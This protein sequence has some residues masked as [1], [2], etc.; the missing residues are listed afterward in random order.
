MSQTSIKLLILICIVP[1]DKKPIF[2]KPRRLPAP[3]REI[4]EQQVEEWIASGIIEPC[5]SEYASPVVV[6][7]KDGTARVCIDY[8]KINRIIEKD[9]HPLPLIEDLLDKLQNVRVFSTLD[10]KNEFF[11]LP[12]EK[13]NRKYTAFVT[14]S[15]QYQF[16]KVPFGLCNSPRVF[17]KFVNAAFW[18][19]IKQNIVLLYVDDLIVPAKD[20]QEALD[21]LKIV[22]E[23]SSAY[24]LQ[25]NL[26]KCQLIKKTIEFLGY[27]VEEGKIYPLP[28]K[29]KAV[30]NYPEPKE[31]KDIQSFLGLSGY[32][33]KFIPLYSVIAKPL[34][35]LLQ[36]NRPYIFDDATR[37]V[38]QHLKT[39]LTQ[40]SVLKIYSPQHETE[41]HMNAS[42]DGYRAVLMQRSPN[43]NLI[44]P[45]YFMSKKTKPIM[46]LLEL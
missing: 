41:V 12:V 21:R 4:V 34:S 38:F 30:A 42:I 40:N 35:D 36:K 32:F 11:H 23:T 9:S 27:V 20:E 19:L 37:N 18:D 8:R 6:K 1:K 26:K 31:L 39:L 3:E 43:D 22:L 33:R 44:H 13:K 5:T 17:Q 24:G 14:H 25:L 46:K 45:V 29:I 28:E 10:L 2:Q 7:K 16:L 15:V